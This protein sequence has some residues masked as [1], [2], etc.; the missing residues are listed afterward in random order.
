MAVLAPLAVCF[1]NPISPAAYGQPIPTNSDGTGGTLRI[2]KGSRGFHSVSASDKRLR[3]SPGA[4]LNGTVTLQAVNVGSNSSMASLVYMPSWGGFNSPWRVTN[5]MIQSGRSDQ[6]APVSL[7]APNAPGTY[8]V[9]FA[10]APEAFFGLDSSASNC[11]ALAKL[12]DAALT[13]AQAKGYASVK[14]RGRSGV[15]ARYVPV[16]ALTIEVS[17]EAAQTSPVAQP[18]AEATELVPNEII[19]ANNAFAFDLYTRLAK[20]PGNF[21]LSP[22]SVETALTLALAGARGQTGDQMSKVLHLAAA[23]SAVHVGL[24]ALIRRLQA[25]EEP[26]RDFV[27]DASMM[28]VPYQL[29]VANSIWSQQGFSF[30]DDF[31]RIGRVQYGAELNQLDFARAPESARQRINDWVVQQTQHKIENIIPPGG[32]DKSTRLVLADAIYFKARWRVEFDK[33][34]TRDAPFHSNPNKAVSVPTMTLKDRFGYKETESLQILEMPYFS[35]KMSQIIL[36]PK[37]MDGLSKLEQSLN[38]T[39]INQLLAQ[40]QEREV[41]VFL[42]KFKFASQFNLVPTLRSMGMTDA[43]TPQADFSG[44][45]SSPLFIDQVLHKAYVD[46]NEEGTEAAAATVI[47]MALAVE[48]P[49]PQPVVFKADHP[50]L[51]LIR[52]NQTGA[53]I[54]MGRVTSPDRN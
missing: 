16:D 11:D 32:L 3:V 39:R 35:G 48:P 5:P 31:L 51:F 8:H 18:A 53:I 45:S 52:H 37:E 36:L 13:E 33:S 54:F 12:S 4:T 46:V 28:G 27:H 30:Q 22:Y 44:M 29:V 20:Q 19:A 6:F 40:A 24:G 7:T 26:A 42:P 50:F 10:S 47:D 49:P 14:W 1:L 17:V 2:V 25:D 38:A 43:F 34:Q 23:G 41:I 21:F 9:I 15:S